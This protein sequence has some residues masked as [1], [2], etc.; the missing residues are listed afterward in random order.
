MVPVDARKYRLVGTRMVASLPEKQS[1]DLMAWSSARSPRQRRLSNELRR[2][3]GEP[4]RV[5]FLWSLRQAHEAEQND[6]TWLRFFLSRD[7]FQDIGHS[8]NSACGITEDTSGVTFV[9]LHETKRSNTR[10]WGAVWDTRDEVTS[11]THMPL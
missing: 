4:L 8:L 10:N 6:V 11:L 5:P 3:F 1:G 2:L 7:A 9:L